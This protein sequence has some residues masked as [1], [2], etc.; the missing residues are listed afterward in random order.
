M[1]VT[2]KQMKV[3]GKPYRHWAPSEQ[4]VKLTGTVRPRSKVKYDEGRN[5]LTNYID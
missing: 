1:P 3:V 4:K 5:K 2:K